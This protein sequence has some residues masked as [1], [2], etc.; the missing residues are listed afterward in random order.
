MN[1]LL[2]IVFKQVTTCNFNINWFVCLVFQLCPTLCDS[3]DCSPPGSSVHEDSPGKNTKVGC[4]ALLQGTFP[5]QRSNP[6]LPHC[7]W[8]LSHLGCQGS[9]RI[10]EWVAYPFSRGS[11][12]PRNRTGV[13]CIA[14]SFFTSWAVLSHWSEVKGNSLSRVLLCDPTDYIVHGIL[15][16]RMLDWVAIPFSR[17]SFPTQGWNPGLS[18]CRWILYQL[19]HQGSPRI[20]EWV[21]YALSSGSF[22]LRN[23]TGTSCT[24]GRF[25]TNWAIR[26]A[27]FITLTQLFPEAWL[28]T[29]ERLNLSNIFPQKGF[30]HHY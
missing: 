3:L 5:T 1:W 6:G 29:L 20:L 13:S 15:Q 12:W 16:A 23:Q 19:S 25:F 21:A 28:W 22:W 24:A 18:H 10:L 4:H 14:G 9:P 7:R 2:Y 11:S 26:E 8:I 30:R 17:G 27:H